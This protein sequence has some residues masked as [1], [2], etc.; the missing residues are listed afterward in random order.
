MVYIVFKDDELCLAADNEM[1]VVKYLDITDETGF[2]VNTFRKKMGVGIKD[3]L[4]KGYRVDELND[5]FLKNGYYIDVVHL[6]YDYR[7]GS[8][9]QY[10]A[11]DLIT[12]EGE[13]K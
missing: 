4:D 6:N 1:D 9:Y 3:W 2:D 12:W 11:M 7:E 10:R 13:P 5:M 8:P